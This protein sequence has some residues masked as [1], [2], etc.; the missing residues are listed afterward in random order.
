LS[1]ERDGLAARLDEVQSERDRL[2]TQVEQL[3]MEKAALVAKLEE[4]R[5]AAKRQ[6]APF[7]RGRP[8]PEHKRKRPGRRAGEN[9]GRTR[10]ATVLQRLSSLGLVDIVDRFLHEDRGPLAGCPCEDAACHHVR[11][12]R[13]ARHPEVPWQN[14]YVFASPAL[15][16]PLSSAIVVG[17]RGNLRIERSCTH[18]LEFH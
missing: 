14:D 9:Y 12:R 18:H 16:A 7:S 15:A 2:A 6:A 3:K 13:D 10:D 5:R 11:T 17:T 4:A 1:A 8:G